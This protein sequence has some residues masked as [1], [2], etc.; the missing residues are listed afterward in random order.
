MRG[1]RMT[2]RGT[3]GGEARGQVAR[4]QRAADRLFFRMAAQGDGAR[5]ADP[6]CRPRYA[7]TTPACAGDDVVVGAHPLRAAVAEG[8]RGASRT[9]AWAWCLVPLSPSRSCCSCFVFTS[10]WLSYQRRHTHGVLRRRGTSRRCRRE[11]GVAQIRWTDPARERIPACMRMHAMAE[12]S[13]WNVSFSLW[14]FPE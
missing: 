5:H 1:R 13:P 2:R 4:D 10:P 6:L 3:K 14:R 7:G 12:L 9:W 8:R 11:F